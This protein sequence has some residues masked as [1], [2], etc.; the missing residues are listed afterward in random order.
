LYFYD[1][2]AS[3]GSGLVEC[4]PGALSDDDQ[5]LGGTLFDNF[6]AWGYALKLDPDHRTT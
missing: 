3:S 1:E 5:L 4:V 6:Y 2:L